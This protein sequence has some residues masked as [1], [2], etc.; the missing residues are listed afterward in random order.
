MYAYSETGEADAED[1]TINFNKVVAGTISANVPVLVKATAAS[2]EQVF[3]GV[4]VVAPTTDVQVAGT[5]A[6]FVGVYA[7]ETIG[8]GHF[9]VKDGALYSS[10]GSASIKAFRAYVRL[11][12]P[13]TT[14]SSV[15]MYIDGLATSISEVNGNVAN[16]E[17]IFNLA[18][19]RVSKVQKGLYIQNG[20]KFFVK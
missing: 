1:I 11:T 20:R 2:S 8:E 4:Q 13:N 18:G 3:N 10:V 5:N 6:S 7:P 14:S 12:N 16:D 17:A 9:Y 19:Q 15:K